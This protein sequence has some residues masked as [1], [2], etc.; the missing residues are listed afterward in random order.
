MSKKKKRREVIVCNISTVG[1]GLEISPKSS[2]S[3]E[4]PLRTKQ[5]VDL[6]MF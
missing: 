4:I 5:N 1:T 2:A 3:H 6:S